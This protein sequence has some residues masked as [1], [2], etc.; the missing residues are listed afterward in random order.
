MV[1]AWIGGRS[2]KDIS[3]RGMATSVKSERLP[4]VVSQTTMEN[5]PNQIWIDDVDGPEAT[6]VAFGVIKKICQ[7]AGPKL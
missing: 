3:V 7:L 1:K 4:H 5:F 2:F 6:Q